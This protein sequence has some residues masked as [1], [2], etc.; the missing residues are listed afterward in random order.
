MAK[1][2]TRRMN[3]PVYVGSS[4]KFPELIV[5]EEMECFTRLTKVIMEQ[6]NQHLRP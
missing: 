1:L 3:V 6:W 2:L 5:E 4:M